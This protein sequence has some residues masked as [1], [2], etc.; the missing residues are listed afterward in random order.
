M[1]LPI[2]DKF[3]RN[4]TSLINPSELKDTTKYLAGNLDNKAKN[5]SAAFAFLL[6][7]ERFQSFGMPDTSLK[8]L[9]SGALKFAIKFSIK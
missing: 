8:F 6:K 9:G 7:F 1:T 3:K 2:F 4:S 5:S